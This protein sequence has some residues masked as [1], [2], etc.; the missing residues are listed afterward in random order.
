MSNPDKASL[1]RNLIPTSAAGTPGTVPLE[2]CLLACVSGLGS[3]IAIGRTVE[4]VGAGKVIARDDEWEAMFQKL[5]RRAAGVVSVPSLHPSTL[6]ELEWIGRQGLF[7]KV[8][9]VITD[10]HT[11]PERPRYALPPLAARLRK[12]GWGLPDDLAPGT[13]LS[14]NS[15][16]AVSTAIPRSRYKRKH[17]RRLLEA[18][19]AGASG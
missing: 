11:D 1:W 10:L 14:F 13:L 18:V 19:M 15:R 9:M 6:W 17:I 4:I 5:A 8:V 16:G 2:E 3:L 12:E 7:A